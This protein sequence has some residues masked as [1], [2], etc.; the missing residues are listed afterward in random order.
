MVIPGRI[1]AGMGMGRMVA[2]VG[3]MSGVM[4][5]MTITR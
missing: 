3:C 2:V 5:L 4:A 1:V